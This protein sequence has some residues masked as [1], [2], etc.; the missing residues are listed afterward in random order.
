M[1]I[2]RVEEHMFQQV[3][4]RLSSGSLTR[5]RLSDI[6][7]RL[8]VRGVLEGL[9]GNGGAR[10]AGRVRCGADADGPWCAA[11]GT[12]GEQPNN[13]WKREPCLN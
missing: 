8:F 12:D 9:A 4:Q 3:T 10:E 7:G 1:V 13:G 5:A 6:S 2:E 11:E